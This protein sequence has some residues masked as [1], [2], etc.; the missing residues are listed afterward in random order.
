MKYLWGFIWTFILVHMLTYVAGSMLSAEYDFKMAS[1][2]GIGAYIL[3]LIISSILP[4]PASA[5]E[6]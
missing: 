4:A 1:I 2:Y 3:V 6:H 5:E